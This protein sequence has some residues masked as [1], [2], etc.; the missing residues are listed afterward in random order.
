MPLALPALLAG[1]LVA[2]L[3]AMTLVRLAGDPGAAGRLPHH[4]DQDLEP[5]PVSAE[6]GACGGRVA[7]AARADRRPA[8]R[9]ARHPRPA[10]LFGGRRQ[11]GRSAADPARLRSNGRRSRCASSCCSIRSSC[12]MARCSTPRSRASPRSSCRFTQPHAAQ[13]RLRVLRAVGD[14]ARAQEHV[15][16][17]RL[18]GDD[19]HGARA[20]DRL[21]DGAQ[22]GRPG[23]ARS[24]FSPPRRS[25]S[26]A[27]CS[28]SAC[29]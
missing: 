19:R 12:P 8:A 22:G 7:A 5:V 3:Q 18:G 24:A 28:A 14:Q 4:D 21:S 15:H 25:R 29:S 11:A 9:R 13:Y 27:S 10:R 26:P 2:F 23:I 6:A 1:A 20:R 16:S 17:R